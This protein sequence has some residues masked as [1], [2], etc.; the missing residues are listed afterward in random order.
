MGTHAKDDY[1]TASRAA[2]LG[3]TTTLIEMCCPNRMEE[4]WEAYQLWRSKAEGI[5]A[6]DFTFHMGISRFDSATEAQLR[7]IVADGVASFKVFLAYKGF[8]GVDDTELYNTLSLAKE[9]GVIVT[10]HCENETIVAELQK[11]LLSEGKTGPEWHEPSRPMQVE[12]EG[13]QHLMSFAEITGAEVYIVH[14]SNSL[15]VQA[16]LEGRR[17]GVRVSIET[18]IPYLVLDDSYAQQ[19][20][21]EGAKYVMSPPIREIAQQ[22]KLWRSLRNREISTVATDHAPFDFH[23]QKEMGRDDFTKI[24]NGIP[25]VEDR[26]NL[27]YTYGVKRGHI[28]LNT[29]VDAGSTQAAKLFG[30][31]PRKGTLAVGSDADIVVYDPDYRGTISAKTHSMATD[32]SAFEG[33]ALEGRPS[34]VW[35]RGQWQVKEGHFVGEPGSGQFLARNPRS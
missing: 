5:A 22:A 1:A 29:F 23:Q 15:A 12:A 3:G 11:R 27:L 32:Y 26:I 28:D 4:P 21:F 35:V 33:W 18:V 9:L 19:P 6:C 13:V 7:R 20:G 30:L 31:F 2:L 16:A 8:F 17:R 34:H 24:P 10:A 14:T 25:T